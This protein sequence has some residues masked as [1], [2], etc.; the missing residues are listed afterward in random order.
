LGDTLAAIY[1]AMGALAALE[2]RRRTGQGQVVDSAIYEACLAITECLVPDY[3][4]AGR[5]RERTG[6]ILPKLAPS[7]VYRTS[8]GMLIIAANQDTVFKRLAEAMGR[9]ELAAD[10]RYATHT[11]RG[12]HQA[13]LDDLIN[14]WAAGFSTDALVAHCEEHGVPSGKIYRAPEMLDDPHY[15]AREAIVSAL[16]PALGEIMMPNVFPKLSETPGAVRSVGRAPGE[17]NEYVYGSLLGCS[18]EEIARL[19]RDGII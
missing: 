19:K 13:E 2:H 1:A 11:A 12:E 7:N 9:P 4:F 8:D 14:A 15:K 17:D 3:Q 6:S 10:P 16:H 5:I 18:E